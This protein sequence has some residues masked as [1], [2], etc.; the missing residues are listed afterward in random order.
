M[1]IVP[2]NLNTLTQCCMGG[3]FTLY[4]TW[5]SSVLGAS[6]KLPL[7]VQEEAHQHHQ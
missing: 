3:G 6:N 2:V 4:M 1:Y 7:E 5:G